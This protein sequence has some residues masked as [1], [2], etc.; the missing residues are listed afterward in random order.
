MDRA[1]REF[2]RI[3]GPDWLL[4]SDDDRD[5]YMDAYALG[6]GRE[7]RPAAPPAAGP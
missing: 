4:A 2:G 1:L 7:H 5:G 6:N 3:V